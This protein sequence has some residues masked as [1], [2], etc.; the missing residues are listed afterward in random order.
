MKGLVGA[1]ATSAL[2][3]AV[4]Q[5]MT[6]EPSLPSRIP[7]QAWHCPEKGTLLCSGRPREPQRPSEYALCLGKITDILR[8][9]YPAFFERE[10]DFDIYADS[11]TMELGPPFSAEGHTRTALTGKAKYC[12]AFRLLRKVM[13]STMR[14]GKVECSVQPAGGLGFPLQINWKCHGEVLLGHRQFDIEAKSLYDLAAFVQAS[15]LP[16]EEPPQLRYL[17]SRHRLEFT[18]IR[19]CSLKSQLLD[20]QKESNLELALAAQQCDFEA[21]G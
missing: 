3:T 16:C 1:R 9:D 12:A 11:V 7:N 4:P 17:V 20:Y 19:P 10:F 6:W 8:S 21:C 2:A 5:A 13:C 14:S 18:A 15:T